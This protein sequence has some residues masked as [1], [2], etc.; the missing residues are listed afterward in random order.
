MAN[1]LYKRADGS[2]FE[3]EHPMSQDAL[4]ACPTTGQPVVRVPQS[5]GSMHG[6]GTDFYKDAKR[7]A[8]PKTYTP[9]A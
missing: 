3:T 6:F 1:Y 9:G 7:A 5:F 8:L 2:L 4:T